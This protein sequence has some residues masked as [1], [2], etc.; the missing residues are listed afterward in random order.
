MAEVRATRK[1]IGGLLL[2]LINPKLKID[3]SAPE[4]R[5]ATHAGDD[6]AKA[7]QSTR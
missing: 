3:G 5:G 1:K 6:N 2:D 4:R 7:G